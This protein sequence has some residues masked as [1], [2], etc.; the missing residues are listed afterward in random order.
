MRTPSL[1]ARLSNFLTPLI[2]LV[3]IVGIWQAAVWVFKTPQYLLPAPSHIVVALGEDFLSLLGHLGITMMEAVAGFLLANVIGFS[4]AV[5]FAHNRTIERG[6][7]PYAIA[8][9]TTPIIAMAPLLVLWLGT[10]FA[11]KIAASALICFFPILV[12]S[13]RGLRAVSHQSLDLF[14]SLNANPLQVF[15]LLRMPTALP[16]IFSALRIST[17]LAVVGAVVGEFV[18]A[19]KGLGYVILVSSYHLETD[20]MFAATALLALGGVAFFSLVALL[21]KRLVFWEYKLED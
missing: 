9:K 13:V 2:F 21:E 6:L 20:M 17:S 16:Y 11:S 19:N 3:A 1:A 14:S 18:G 7:Y 15:W 4:V 5:V 8:L 10:G 12:N